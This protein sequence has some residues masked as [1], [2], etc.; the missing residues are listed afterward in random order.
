MTSIHMAD[1]AEHA[2]DLQRLKALRPIDDEFMRCMFRDNIPLTQQVLQIIM[3]KPDLNVISVETQADLKRLAGARSVC[4][5][6]YASDSDGRIYDIEIQRDDSGADIRRARYHSS[7]IDIDNLDKSAEFTDLPESCV[8]FITESDAIGFGDPVNWFLTVMFP[9][10]II[11]ED[12]R[13]IIYVNGAYR[14]DDDLGRLMHD[15][16]CSDPNDMLIPEMAERTRYFKENEKGV[17]EMSSVLDEMKQEA[18][19][20]GIEKGIE[21]GRMME[22]TSFIKVI[23]QQLNYTENQA[24]DFLKIP[25]DE[26]SAYIDALK[27]SN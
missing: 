9:E 22:K 14:G 16:S 13:S 26:R 24:M 6:V 19:Q 1:N 15:F 2:R 10:K 3:H 21:K 11:A 18:M 17:I 20:Q 27:K 4:L 7:A 12:G 25:E 5:D 8:I 23:M